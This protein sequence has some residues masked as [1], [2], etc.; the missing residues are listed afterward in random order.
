MII[1]GGKLELMTTFLFPTGESNPREQ[2]QIKDPT[3]AVRPE[4]IEALDQEGRY[5]QARNLALWK[6]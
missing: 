4:G 1:K 3:S 6:A 2:K 5:R